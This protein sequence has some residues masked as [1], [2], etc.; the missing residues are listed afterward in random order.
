MGDTAATM[1]RQAIYRLLYV[2]GSAAAD[3][4]RYRA[5]DPIPSN[6]RELK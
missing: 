6:S 4:L 5:D 3:D 1:A 2:V